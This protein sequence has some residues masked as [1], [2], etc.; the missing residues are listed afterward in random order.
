M[1]LV[2]SALCISSSYKAPPI[3]AEEYNKVHI[4][5]FIFT[6]VKGMIKVIGGAPS[7]LSLGSM[8]LLISGS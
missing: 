8:L 5:L 7:W 6:C 1:T 4:E 2:A 3:V